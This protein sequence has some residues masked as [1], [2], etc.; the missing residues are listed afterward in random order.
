MK[1]EDARIIFMGTSFFAEK[2]LEN[3]V[4]NEIKIELVVTQPDK[5]SGRKKKLKSSEVKVFAQKNNLKLEQFIKLD[6]IALKK[7]K[8]IKPDLVIIAAYGMIIPANFLAIPKYGFINIHTSLLPKLRG[9][10][11]IQT[12]LSQGIDKT[13]ITIMKIDKGLDSGNIISQKEILIENSDKYSDLEKKLIAVS[14][15]ILTK[16]L[17]SYLE[18]LKTISQDDSQATFTKIIK[19]QNGQINWNLNAKDIWNNFRA[20][21]N[22]P[23]IYTFDSNG[24]KLILTE[25]SLSQKNEKEKQPGEVY[26][27]KDQILIKTKRGSI[28]LKKVKLEGKNELAIKD[29]INGNPNLTGSLL[30]S[31]IH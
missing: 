13:G 6:R 14:S 2:I 28:I 7:I 10:S 24:K 17:S 23:Q 31:N 8:A 25:I 30:K 22:W 5:K 15:D 4:E 3:L 11:P 26:R 12:A 21:Y 27:R 16:T 20:Y 9:A 18:N 1:L 19:K 29:F